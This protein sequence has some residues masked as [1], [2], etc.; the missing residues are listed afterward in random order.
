MVSLVCRASDHGNINDF[1]VCRRSRVAGAIVVAQEDILE[2]VGC[3]CD[4]SLLILI[5]HVSRV[6]FRV[7]V[8]DEC[9]RILTR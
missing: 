3:Q 6:A 4:D 8:G 9:R 5:E 1:L 7:E 2:L